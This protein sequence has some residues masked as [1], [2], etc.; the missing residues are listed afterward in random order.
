MGAVINGHCCGEPANPNVTANQNELIPLAREGEDNS[1]DLLFRG[2]PGDGTEFAGVNESDQWG[3]SSFD[4][5]YHSLESDPS[6][7]KTAL[8]GDTSFKKSSPNT[9][10]RAQEG[11]EEG[12]VAS[13]ERE[14]EDRKVSDT[15][16]LN[17]N[18]AGSESDGASEEGWGGSGEESSDMEEVDPEWGE[19][20]NQEQGWDFS[21]EEPPDIGE[22]GPELSE[23][24]NQEQ[25]WDFSGEEPP[26]IGEVGPELSE[27][28]DQEEG[29]GGTGDYDLPRE[30]IVQPSLLPSGP[31]GLDPTKDERRRPPALRIR[32][33]TRLQKKRDRYD[34]LFDLYLEKMLKVQR[35]YEKKGPRPGEPG[36]LMKKSGLHEVPKLTRHRFRKLDSALRKLEYELGVPN[37]GARPWKHKGTKLPEGLIP[38][39]SPSFW[40]WMSY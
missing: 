20:G 27:A 33:Q 31:S 10:S 19:A 21:G 14:S 2:N 8:P 25:G 40:I 15:S 7:G 36:I 38:N 28:G 18:N 26:D 37:R 29:W 35:W 9:D 13:P 12:A 6:S 5:D 1:T 4:P 11:N 30:E 39:P 22:V 16:P 17:K 3:P 24:G 34:R 32:S 23:A